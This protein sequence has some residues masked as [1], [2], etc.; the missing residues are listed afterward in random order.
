MNQGKGIEIC[1]SLR[2]ITNSLRAKS[3][4][5][6]WVVQ[7]YIEK[8]L[9]FNGRKFDIRI[10]GLVTAKRELFCYRRGY[11]RTSSIEYDLNG[12]DNYIHLTNN[13]LQQLGENYGVYEEGNTLSLED[14][15]NYLKSTFPEYNLMFN[16]HFLPRIKDLMIDTYLSCKKSIHKDKKKHMFELLGFDFL[17][18][19]DFRVWLLEV[20]TNPYLGV[21]NPYIETLLPEMLDDMLEITVDTVIP[22]AYPKRRKNNDFEL[23]FC[24]IGSSFSKDG[25]AVNAR[26]SFGNSLYPIPELAQIQLCKQCIAYRYE[27]DS[28]K[29]IAKD[30]VQVVKNL[31]ENNSN[32]EGPEFTG[33]VLKIVV[34]LGNWVLNSDISMKSAQALKLISSSS[35]VVALAEMQVMKK[36]IEILQDR[37]AD[38]KIQREVLEIIVNGF[39]NISFRKQAV[40]QGVIGALIEMILDKR[41]QETIDLCLSALM[42][43]CVNPTKHIYLPGKSREYRFIKERLILHGGILCLL[44]V[45][46]DSD[47]YKEKINNL[48]E[49]E[50]S[51]NDW[52][53]QLSV[54]DENLNENL[55]IAVNFVKKRLEEFK[56][57]AKDAILN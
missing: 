33:I 55:T 32:F 37:E 9:L 11:V 19:E 25:K 31:L 17:I 54:I 36:I 56:Q 12:K 41:Q 52:K 4:S 51:I 38:L 1:R 21:P 2:E 22:P 40:V 50:F 30:A 26:Q 6:L 44:V 23:I 8:P 46:S 18:D 53:R 39:E 16:T 48:L 3:T 29:L 45:A 28:S 5:S 24:E 42:S 47:E 27:E 35:A 15:E 7:K 14:F 57:Y 20:N 10:W 43:L 13:C 34:Q 49:K